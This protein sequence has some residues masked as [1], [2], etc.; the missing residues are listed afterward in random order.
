MGR[1]HTERFVATTSIGVNSSVSAADEEK[2]L[3]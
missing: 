3:I 2:K 1:E